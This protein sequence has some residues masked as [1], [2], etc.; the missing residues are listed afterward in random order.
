MFAR[1]RGKGS[2]VQV[3]RLLQVGFADG[4]E[5]LHGHALS[6]RR[7]HRRKASLVPGGP[8]G[9]AR[10]HVGPLPHQLLVLV[11]QLPWFALAGAQRLRTNVQALAA[12]A[13]SSSRFG[14]RGTAP[15]LPRGVRH[16]GSV[17]PAPKVRG[18]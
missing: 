11:P 5:V 12:G 15:K 7:G 2:K 18:H 17:G 3:H 14:N 16:P 4:E 6:Q 13:K 8:N 1:S 9:L 10:L